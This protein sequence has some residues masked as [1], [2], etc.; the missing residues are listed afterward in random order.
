MNIDIEKLDQI[1]NNADNI[2]LS[3][4][5][6]DVLIEF[7]RIKEQVEQ[8][9]IMI[10][11]KL[12][13]TGMKN[14]PHFKEISGQRV[15]VSYQAY[16]AKYSIDT[17][18]IDHL[19]KNLYRVDTKYV[20]E[21]KSIEQYKKEYN[22][23]PEGVIANHRKKSIRVAIK[24]LTASEYTQT[25]SRFEILPRSCPEFEPGEAGAEAAQ[26]E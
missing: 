13:E 12:L 24:K 18:K 23:L 25:T 2:F 15:K 3:R 10:K 17:S 5:A 4:E 11:Q 8:A 9:E 22:T 20:P 21:S 6:E 16:G 1:V 7:Y 19:P 26:L 14:S